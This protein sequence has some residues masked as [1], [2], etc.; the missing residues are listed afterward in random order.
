MKPVTNYDG[1]E[2]A[3][4][5]ARVDALIESRAEGDTWLDLYDRVVRCEPSGNTP[6]D[7]NSNEGVTDAANARKVFDSTLHDAIQNIVQ[8]YSIHA[9]SFSIPMRE[10]QDPDVIENDPIQAAE[11][12]TRKDAIAKVTEF[13]SA[14]LVA[15]NRFTHKDL[16][17]D[18]LWASCYGLVPITP[19]C[20]A[21][22]F[23]DVMPTD[24]PPFVL[25][26]DKPRNSYPR[27]S[28]FGILTEH[29]VKV[30]STVASVKDESGEAAEWLEGN[31]DDEAT[32][33]DYMSRTWH[34]VYVE[35]QSDKPLIAAE[36]PKDVFGGIP[37]VCQRT[38][39]GPGFWDEDDELASYGKSYIR[40]GTYG[41][42]NTFYTVL[43]TL[44]L[45][46][47][48]VMLV[49]KL[50]PGNTTA[51]LPDFALQ[52][53]TLTGYQPN[54]GIEPVAL[55]TVPQE[56]LTLGQV[57]GF[58]RSQQIAPSVMNGTTPGGIFAASALSLLV[59][60]GR[61]R[62][63]I[64]RRAVEDALSNAFTIVLRWM[65]ARAGEG[66][67]YKVLDD[68]GLLELTAA[69]LQPLGDDLNVRVTLNPDQAMERMAQ[70]N[71][72]G[73]LKAMGLGA[74]EWL[75][76]LVDGG[77]IESIADAEQHIIDRAAFEAELPKIAKEMAQYARSLHGIANAIPDA[78]APPPPGMMSPDIQSPMSQMA[79]P[80]ALPPVEALP[81][82]P[83]VPP[84]MVEQALGGGGE[85]LA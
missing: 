45:N 73:A 77:V 65:K 43:T 71:T 23:G 58:Q 32:I 1:A 70:V 19:T 36:I 10:S 38:P 82:M 63:F 85:G 52:Q 16:V 59:S 51:Q 48:S 46:Y 28:R 67:L 69:D 4:V 26:V 74:P 66:D 61:L 34:W 5:K 40:S 76:P 54:E 84:E 62:T 3:R 79:N 64:I 33:V 9:P 24:A 31:D 50:Q 35:K 60:Q 11:V 14:L 13:L 29:V 39:G 44:A 2:Y 15:N 12:E 47:A 78:Y 22:L 25:S 49:Q 42:F 17:A 20:I 53:Q 72:A 6:S 37:R 68:G 18:A 56:L 30:V 41:F 83:P 81:D 57:F 27:R 80:D 75:Q 7:P 21:E 8:M 55:R